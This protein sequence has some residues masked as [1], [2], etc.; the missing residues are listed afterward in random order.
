M[1]FEPLF[2]HDH[3]WAGS[4]TLWRSYCDIDLTDSLVNVYHGQVHD[5]IK[6]GDDTGR[7]VTFLVFEEA[8]KASRMRRT[9][10]EFFKLAPLNMAKPLYVWN[11]KSGAE[12]VIRKHPCLV[13]EQV[14][15][16][17]FDKWNETASEED[18]LVLFRSLFSAIG[19]FH[20]DGKYFANIRCGIR[21]IGNK[22]VFVFPKELN[23]TTHDEDW[24]LD[25]GIRSDLKELY[26]MVEDSKIPGNSEKEHFKELCQEYAF[27]DK[28]QGESLRHGSFFITHSSLVWTHTDRYNIVRKLGEYQKLHK[29]LYERLTDDIIIEETVKNAIPID[30][31][32]NRLVDHGI[33]K[34]LYDMYQRDKYKKGPKAYERTEGIRYFEQNAYEHPEEAFGLKNVKTAEVL[35]SVPEVVSVHDAVPG[36]VSVHVPVSVSVPEVVS[37]QDAVPDAVPGVSVSVPPVPIPVPV[38]VP[39][40]VD[41]ALS[42]SVLEVG[43][44]LYKVYPEVPTYLYRMMISRLH[45]QQNWIEEEE[46]IMPPIIE[47]MQKGTNKFAF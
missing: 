15:T 43:K 28:Y 35:V 33:T 1:A 26:N 19:K 13:I 31:L 8:T 2:S 18:L 9:L 36:P 20:E 7:M 16:L 11:L 24:K 42:L 45:F 4:A 47:F 22:P 10:D 12:L 34:G 44:L 29:D 23:D 5:S 30:N 27:T 37:V 32:W 17:T 6:K 41:A 39:Q 38:S 46:A 40:V 3:K 14:S 21:I 25:T